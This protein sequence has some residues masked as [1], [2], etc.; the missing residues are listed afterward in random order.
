MSL[1]QNLSGLI[2][3]PFESIHTYNSTSRGRTL[4]VS[5]EAV[6]GFFDRSNSSSRGRTLSLEAV[7]GFVVRP[8]CE[9]FVLLEDSVLLF[10]GGGSWLQSAI[11]GCVI[12]VDDK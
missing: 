6:D 3:L 12:V 9:G 2:L 1:R 11:N 5:L 4:D 8:N 10:L 7:D